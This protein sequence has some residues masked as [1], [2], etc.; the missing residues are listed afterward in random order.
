MVQEVSTPGIVPTN[1]EAFEKT[2]YQKVNL[3]GSKKRQ[4]Q[5]SQMFGETIGQQ[6]L[7]N[8]LDKEVLGFWL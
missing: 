6:S 5:D 1:P 8:A 2:L 3:V 7:A 4:Y